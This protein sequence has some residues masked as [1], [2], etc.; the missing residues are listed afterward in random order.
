MFAYKIKTF[1]DETSKGEPNVFFFYELAARVK[2]PIFNHILEIVYPTFKPVSAIERLPSF[3]PLI[4]SNLVC[5]RDKTQARQFG[6][7]KFV[8]SSKHCKIHVHTVRIQNSPESIKK[9]S[10]L[11]EIPRR[12]D[13]KNEINVISSYSNLPVIRWENRKRKLIIPSGITLNESNL[14][15]EG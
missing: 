5:T 10:M 4:G 9:G 6:S 1:S 12:R 13:C 14:F 15:A 3:Y 11:N 8:S 7:A 2:F